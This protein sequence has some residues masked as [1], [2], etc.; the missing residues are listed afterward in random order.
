MK[1]IVLASRNK[2]KLIEVRKF[3]GE[4]DPRIKLSSI[5]DTPDI[6]EI[7][8]TGSTFEE[9]A[10]IKAKAVYNIMGIP[11]IADDSGLEVDFLG[12]KPGVFSARYS[13]KNASDEDNCRKLLNELKNVKAEERTAKFRCVIVFYHEGKAEICEGR[14]DGRI[15]FEPKGEKGFGYDP[16]FIPKGF[17]ETFG[18]LPVEIKNKISHRGKALIALTTVIHDIIKT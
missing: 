8:E 3:I 7:E 1:R 10:L 18:E 15:G 16:L 2:G 13:G 11:V 17:S 4:F 14:C 5:A 6:P 9:N 12:G